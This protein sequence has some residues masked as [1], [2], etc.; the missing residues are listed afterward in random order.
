MHRLSTFV[1]ALLT[2]TLQ[3]S[4]LHA[5]VAR[6]DEQPLEQLDPNAEQS[7]SG[8]SLE[9]VIDENDMQP[10]RE[11]AEGDII[12]ELG[13]PVG[14][15][16]VHFA[17]AKSQRGADGGYCTASLISNDLILTNHHCIAGRKKSAKA[18][19]T[20]GYIEPRVRF[21]IAQY[22]VDLNPVEA[23]KDLDYAIL[24]VAG[25][26]GQIWGT[27]SL[28]DRQP[29]ARGSLF[30]IHY[31]LG[32]PQHATRGRCRADDPALMGDDL[33]HV[34]DTLPGSSGAPIFDNNTLEVV[35]LHY[36]ALDLNKSNAGKLMKRLSEVSP[37]ISELI[38]KNR[39]KR[40]PTGA[41]P[42]DRRYSR[43]AD[44]ALW[45]TI[46][47]NGQIEVL[48]GYLNQFPNGLFAPTA[49]ILLKTGKARAARRAREL[50][51]REKTK[52]ERDA[53]QQA[54]DSEIR[55]K[56]ANSAQFRRQIQQMLVKY[57]VDPGPANGVFG[58][59]TR[60]AVPH[61]APCAQP[62]RRSRD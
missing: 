27:V 2:C 61:R 36:A 28:S 37:T 7:F 18:L 5:Q 46:K 14:R 32:H 48:E 22:P 26:P 9:K 44:I 17:K 34:C 47:S 58:D 20:M 49:R 52:A 12:R 19:L 3:V 21:E 38:R 31:P 15:L 62:Y 57:G 25:S 30:L 53:K 59:K 33:M 4:T 10:T 23:S 35:G 29:I 56:I 39:L 43:N 51:E 16:T 13:R 54:R 45:N 8:R 60:S 42:P 6:F 24:R 41:L 55:E 1:F 11:F 40:E 50:A